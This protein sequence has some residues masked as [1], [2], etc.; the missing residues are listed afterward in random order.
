MSK[1]SEDEAREL[2]D[3]IADAMDAHEKPTEQYTAGRQLLMSY[4]LMNP[5][6]VFAVGQASKYLLTRI[7]QEKAA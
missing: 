1:Q 4:H 2:I 6:S 3:L 7:R 5:A